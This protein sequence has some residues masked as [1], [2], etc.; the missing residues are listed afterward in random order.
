MREEIVPMTFEFSGEKQEFE[1]SVDKKDYVS[2]TK[3]LFAFV[4]TLH[5]IKLGT[6]R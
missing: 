2:F 6:F 3:L 4:M 1:V 5:E